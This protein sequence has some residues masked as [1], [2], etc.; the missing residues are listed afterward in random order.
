MTITNIIPS[1]DQL[2]NTTNKRTKHPPFVLQ[3]VVLNQANKLLKKTKKEEK[4]VREIK[5]L[6]KK[7][8]SQLKKI[9]SEL[10]NSQ[11]RGNAALGAINY[12][13]SEMEN[14]IGNIDCKLLVQIS[15]YV[16]CL[17][18]QQSTMAQKEQSDLETAK[19]AISGTSGATLQEKTTDYSETQSI[20]ENALSVLK[21]FLSSISS[22]L[23]NTTSDSQNITKNIQP[24]IDILTYLTQRLHN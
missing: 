6:M 16:T 8:I 3:T 21:N 23:T 11:N 5:Q 1:S 15:D 13:I 17:T 10:K 18:Q 9:K 14:L 4:E 2:D 24:V 22:Y 20:Y 12:A 19:N 7:I